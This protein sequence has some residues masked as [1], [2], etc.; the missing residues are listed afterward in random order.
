MFLVYV[1]VIFLYN[2]HYIKIGIPKAFAFREMLK[3]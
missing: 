3:G 2:F 1:K